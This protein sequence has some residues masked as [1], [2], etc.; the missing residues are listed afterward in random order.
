MEAFRSLRW[1]PSKPSHL[2]YP[3]AQILLVGESSGIKKAV[4]ADENDTK[5]KQEPGVVLEHLEEE[6][7]QR[8]KHL[9][10]D[11]STSIF[12]DLQVR[13]ND[14]PELQTTF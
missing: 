1:L 5:G 13:A 4:E 14:Y 11:Q 6:D 7:L 3:N 8:M 12:A 10:G 2:D 9:S